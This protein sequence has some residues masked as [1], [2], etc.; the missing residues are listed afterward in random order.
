MLTGPS[1]CA[2]PPS[3][4]KVIAEAH[5]S[6][7]APL[8][9]AKSS[10]GTLTPE[11]RKHLEERIAALGPDGE[12]LKRHIAVEESVADSPL[13]IEN[14]VTLLQDGPATYASMIEAMESARESI[15]VEMY[16][17]EADEIGNKF[18]DLWLR[19]QKAG[20][21]VSLLYDSV[22]SISTP[23]EYFE[24][25][26]QGGV[27]VTEFNPVNPLKAKKGWELNDRDHRKLLIVDGR[28]GFVGGINISGVY[29]GGSSTLRKKAD[30]GPEAQRPW[31]DTQVRLEGPIVAELQ[32]SYF[33]AWSK[34]AKEPPPGKPRQQAPRAAGKDVARVLQGWADET[35]KVNPIYATFASAI[36]SAQK[37]VHLTMAYF[38]PDPETMKAMKDAAKRGVD[39]TL[40]LPSFTDFWGVFHAGRSKYDDLLE[41][42]VKI[43]ERKE[44][45]LHAKTA[46]IDGVWSTVGSANLDWRS[47]LH[48]HELNIVVLGPEFGAQ[49]EAAFKRDIANSK[50][51]TLEEWR[52]RPVKDRALE[53]AARL[54]EYWL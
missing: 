2:T 43:Y 14:K 28:V 53:T 8:A 7:P 11:Q 25:L 23:K 9:N 3:A 51:V 46:V 45:L 31:R 41:S 35:E 27:T 40:I 32:K 20:V 38:V 39:V 15:H 4:G 50:P 30:K 17:V 6:S 10:K 24:R 37:S 21:P 22:G 47:F 1:G 42:G 52:K 34:A 16:I 33:E 5:A 19:K 29:S 44:R 49:M 12:M 54:W 36:T 13:T 18:A 48:N 26:R